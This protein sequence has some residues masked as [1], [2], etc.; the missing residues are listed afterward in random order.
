MLGER[1]HRILISLLDFLRSSLHTGCRDLH[2]IFRVK[3]RDAGGV[4]FVSIL[5]VCGSNSLD[6]LSSILVDLLG[7]R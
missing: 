5:H 7:R 6:L 4:V 1:F 2:T 3:S